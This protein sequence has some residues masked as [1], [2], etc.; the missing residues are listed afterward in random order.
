[1]N[2]RTTNRKTHSS[3]GQCDYPIGYHIFEF[4][5]ELVGQAVGPCIE[6]FQDHRFDGG[7]GKV[8]PFALVIRCLD[9]SDQ[10]IK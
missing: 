1:M 9:V 6:V 7:V 4:V 2:G 8:L 10:Q 3:N 5:G